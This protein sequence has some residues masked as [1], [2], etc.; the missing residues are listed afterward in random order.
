[1]NILKVFTRQRKIGNFGEAAAA[2]L[3]KKKGYKILERNY[4]AFSSE[5]DIIAENKTTLAFIE[6]KTRTVEKENPREARP[7][8]AVTPDKQRKIINAAKCYIAT[9]RTEKRISLDVIEVYLTSDGRKGS[10]IHIENAFNRNSA[11]EREYK[12]R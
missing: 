7:A 6:V 4:V 8:S 2:K 10:V 1:M 12:I 3:L 11:Y 5:I 9:H